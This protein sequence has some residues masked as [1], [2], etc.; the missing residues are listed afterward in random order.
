MIPAALLP[1]TCDIYRGNPPVGAAVAVAV[2]C[3]LVAAWALGDRIMGATMRN[4]TD[5]LLVQPGVD[6]RDS[7]PGTVG[8][9]NYAAADTVVVPSGSDARYAVVFVEVR[10][11]GTPLHHQRVYLDRTRAPWQ[12]APGPHFITQARTGLRATTGTNGVIYIA[13]G[14]VLATTTIVDTFEGFL[15]ATAS[16]VPLNAMRDPRYQPALATGPDG[17]VYALGGSGPLGAAINTV[18]V[19]DRHTGLWTARAALAVARQ[20]PAAVANAS[21]LYV[22]GGT[23]GV[24][25]FDTA[26][27]YDVALDA[28]TALANMPGGRYGLAAARGLGNT[29]YL[30]GGFDG[31]AVDTFHRYDTLSDSY[32]ALANMTTPRLLHGLVFAGGFVYAIGGQTDVATATDSCERYDPL[33]DTWTPIAPMAGP[34]AD[35]GCTLGPDGKIYVFGGFDTVAELDTIEAYDPTTNTWATI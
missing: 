28:W 27:R 22:F 4:Y 24:T 1:A 21:F 35:H 30:S 33:T 19:F 20:G 18:E 11:L 17:K 12:L 26:A 6:I 16:A 5:Y 7:F 34:R 31:G 3:Q 23:D 15:V 32:H 8:P 9:W 10:G 14:K 2:P 13:G 25:N 29:I